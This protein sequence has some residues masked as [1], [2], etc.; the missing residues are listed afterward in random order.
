MS[1]QGA[2]CPWLLDEISET[3]LG[4]DEI[5]KYFFPKTGHIM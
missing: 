2:V 1:G 4:G 5:G 3:A